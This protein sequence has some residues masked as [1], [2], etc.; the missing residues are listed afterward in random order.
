MTGPLYELRGV[1]VGYRQAPVFEGL[2]LD[3]P[4]GCF[5]AVIGPNGGGKST[6]LGTLSRLLRPSQGKIV[7]EGVDLRRLSQRDVARIVGLVPQV[8]R[9]DFEFTV[10]DI[11]LM[12]RYPHLSGLQAPGSADRR[13]AE[14]AMAATG[15][16]ALRERLA[17]DLSGGEY[18]RV[19]VARCLTQ[20]P[21]VLLLDEPTAHLDLTYQ[22]EILD[23]VKRL[24]A[25]GLSVIAVLHDLNLAAQFFDDFILVAGG[26]V[27]ATGDSGH[28]LTGELLSL[29]Y[30]A[31]V[32]VERYELRRHDS[33]REDLAGPGAGGRDDRFFRF[34]IERHG[35]PS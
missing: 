31:T 30:G 4:R 23:L 26:R 21:R 2:S 16:L 14:R 25:G 11:V 1:T 35:G 22:V 24:N 27:M 33:I 13:V 7:L 32:R 34:L 28:V 5:T 6:L 9:A 20:E 15:V 17:G 3:I 8:S 18:Q 29:A 10:E 12:G 19:L